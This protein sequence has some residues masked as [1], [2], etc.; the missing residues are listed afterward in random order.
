V[1]GLNPMLQS[2]TQGS[3]KYKV[4]FDQFFQ[5][6]IDHVAALAIL[7]HFLLWK[8]FGG[9]SSRAIVIYITNS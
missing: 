5:L 1:A 4:E 3:K 6:L 7:T 9:V 8:L 2:L